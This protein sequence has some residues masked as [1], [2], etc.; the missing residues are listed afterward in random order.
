M[1]T[2]KIKHHAVCFKTSFA[3]LMEGQRAQ[4]SMPLKSSY[5]SDLKY[6][7]VFSNSLMP[8]TLLFLIHWLFGFP[9]HPVAI[10]FPFD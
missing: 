10:E 7:S 8:N 2:L 5:L 6:Y 9:R 3:K 4:K 1:R